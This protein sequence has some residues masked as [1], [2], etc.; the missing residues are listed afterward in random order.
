[1]TLESA[2][3]SHSKKV[4]GTKGFITK[5]PTAPNSFPLEQGQL[6]RLCATAAAFDS[7]SM[8]YAKK[9]KVLLCMC[10]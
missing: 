4:F 8:S 7:A 5:A 6:E 3:M 9:R 2:L 1:M 10:S